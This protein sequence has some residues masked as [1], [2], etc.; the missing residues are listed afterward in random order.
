M[1]KSPSAPSTRA[2]LG[3]LAVVLVL[4]CLANACGRSAASPAKS[5]DPAPGAPGVA[6]DRLPDAGTP[7][8]GGS[9]AFGLEGET[10]SLSPVTGRWA[11]SGHMV[12]SA[13]FDSLAVLDDQGN[14]VPELASSFT[15]NADN[16]EWTVTLK[17]GIT[18]HDGEPFNAAAVA[19]ALRIYKTALITGAVFA[20]VDTITETG[21]MTVTITTKQP[22][23]NIANL[24][25]G[26]AG[27]MPAPAM[28][29]DPHGGEHPI[30][31]GP[32]MFH[33]WVKNDHVT[34]VKNPHYWKAGLPHLDQIT[35][36]PIENAADRVSA[37]QDGTL[38]A[39]DTF[40]PDSIR[41][42]RDDPDL[43]YLE[44]AQGEE[45]HIALN[46]MA[47]PFDNLTARQ[48][49]ATATDQATYIDQI[50]KDVYTPA[51]GMFAPGQLGYTDDSGYPTFDL[52]KAKE[53]VAEYTQQT[54]KPLAFTLLAT[55]DIEYTKQDQLLKT[56]WEAAGMQVTLAS[57]PQ[58]DEVITVVLGQ[59]QAA[60]FRL[61][62]SPDPDA[63]YHWW[64]STAVAPPGQVS[65]N[66]TRFAGA[67]TDRALDA[68]RASTDPA[69]R[70]QDYQAFERAW[71]AAVPYIWLAR[72]DWVL[73]S[74]PQVHGYEAG[75]NGSV[76]TLGAKPWIADL[77]MG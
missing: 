27:Y 30:G 37:L 40:F 8:D 38:N 2:P 20:V 65:I 19:K 5:A 46:T 59:Y 52:D 69:T 9:L 55:G 28:L 22:V 62:G 35:F 70:D 29:D 73:A 33:E 1:K 76:Q 72:A 18:F 60:D 26:Q 24:F 54:G 67:E 47:P 16:T 32:F 77:W 25:V 3:L 57:K 41:T 63:D 61:F 43:R 31:T 50:G 48:A 34:V 58:A 64:S 13:I 44:Y 21:P 4:A 75:G 66:M 45:L 17:E 71:N 49:V 36:K 42:I 68:A 14:A 53:L 6:T 15:P 39:I 10:D 56:M 23:G 7:K 74:T 51:N 12:G 11:L